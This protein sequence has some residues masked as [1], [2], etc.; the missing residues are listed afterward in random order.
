MGIES[1]QSTEDSVADR[2]DR[3]PRSRVRHCDRPPS[4]SAEAIAH[5]NMVRRSER[6][7]I[8]RL[9]ALERQKL[10]RRCLPRGPGDK[11][12]LIAWS[13]VAAM[14]DTIHNEIVER[15]KR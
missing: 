6:M 7:R 11:Q 15:R 8:R 14:F 3:L 1:A 4:L 10:S 12:V 9:V 2:R 5:G 13:E